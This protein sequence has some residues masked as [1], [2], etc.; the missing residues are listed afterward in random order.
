[1]VILKTYMSE[2]IFFVRDKEAGPETAFF[3]SPR[4]AMLSLAGPLQAEEEQEIWNWKSGAR[5]EPD[6]I[7]LDQLSSVRSGL[8]DTAPH[9][10]PAQVIKKGE[11]RPKTFGRY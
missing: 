3:V 10:P 6:Q 4:R 5:Q 7:D 11:L 9:L 8:G 1:M 2:Y